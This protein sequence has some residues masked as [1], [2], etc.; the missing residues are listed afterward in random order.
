MSWLGAVVGGAIG[1]FLE[2]G[3]LGAVIGGVIGHLAT[4]SGEDKA[5]R[6]SRRDELQAA[7]ITA[8]F[9][10]MAKVAKADGAVTQAEADYIKAFIQAN[11]RQD[12]KQ[13]I[14]KVFNAAR[15][16]D[17]SYRQYINEFDQLLGYNRVIKQNFLGLLCELAAIDGDLTQK[18]REILLYAEQV[19]RLHGYV[20]AFFRVQTENS[21]QENLETYYKILEVSPEATDQELKSAY[22]K[23]CIEFHPDKLQSKGLPPEMLAHAENEMRRINQAYDAI[24]AFRAKQPGK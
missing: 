5:K 3:P 17:V 11:F 10:C 6:A 22:R 15:D 19:F 24:C 4:G 13:F 14:H 12:Q 20:N 2:A 21:E 1:V 16:N 8:L 18:E 9:S 7:F 23:K